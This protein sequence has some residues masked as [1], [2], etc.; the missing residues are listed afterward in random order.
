MKFKLNGTPQ[1]LPSHEGGRTFREPDGFGAAACDTPLDPDPHSAPDDTQC[2]GEGRR[3]GCLPKQVDVSQASFGADLDHF[4]W[5]WSQCG[6]RHMAGTGAAS[7]KSISATELFDPLMVH[8]RRSEV[9]PE[10]FQRRGQQSSAN[11]SL[12]NA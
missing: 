12:K 6:G 3:S 2:L 9:L 5:V 7:Q 8:S 10:I 4:A 1:T 11:V